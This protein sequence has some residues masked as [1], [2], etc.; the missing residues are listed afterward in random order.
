MCTIHIDE[1][2]CLF[3][4]LKMLKIR[5]ICIRHC[6]YINITGAEIC[7]VVTLPRWK[8]KFHTQSGHP[9]CASPPR[10]NMTRE[11]GGDG[12]GSGGG[13]RGPDD[14]AMAPSLARGGMVCVC[15]RVPFCVAVANGE[16]V[17][18]WAC[19]FPF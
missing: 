2:P 11:Q 16:V 5:S 17:L 1:W 9:N 10:G 7:A 6:N 12:H 3:A 13:G 15:D 19:L 4:N 18:G 8:T 14:D